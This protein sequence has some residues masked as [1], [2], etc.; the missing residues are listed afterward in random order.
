MKAIVITTIFP[1]TPAAEAFAVMDG[2]RL[3]VVG[4]RK[5]PAGW[6]LPGAEFIGADQQEQIPF[7]L[8]KHLPYNHYCRKMIGYLR[9]MADHADCIADT[10]D[11]NIPKPGWGF[12]EFSSSYERIPGDRGFVNIYSLFSD[13]HIWPRGLPLDRIT[14]SGDLTGSGV[15]AGC[16]VGVWQGLAD[17]DPDVDAVY[18][19][20]SDK[21]CYFNDRGPVVLG[22]GTLT[23]F[24]TQNTL[25]RRELFPLLY[26]PVT[27]TFRFTDILRGL[28]AQPVMWLYGY[29]LGF[30][31]ASVIQK[32]N[33]HDYMKDFAS[34]VPM[35]MLGE[36]VPGIVS[37]ALDP[38]DT[39][40]GNL[41]RAYEALAG[42]GI[43]MSGELTALEAWIE[44]IGNIK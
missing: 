41:Y 33:P 5:T 11:D 40:S 18:R 16:N 34:E 30:V 21:P 37:S 22:R 43:V 15:K 28:V 13:Q 17:E 32:R 42:R 8:I 1:P 25:F 44:D 2:Y 23:P 6:H 29:E 14:G 9:A 36:S 19:L 3:Y 4:D 20:T 35:Y 27:V 26:L 10:D 39:V 7:G 12:P 31:G 38:S 24:N